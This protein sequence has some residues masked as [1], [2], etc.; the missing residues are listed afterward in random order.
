MLKSFSWDCDWLTLIATTELFSDADETEIAF[1]Y[2]LF[3]FKQIMKSE[4]LKNL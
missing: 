2:Y 1:F 3:I 4:Y